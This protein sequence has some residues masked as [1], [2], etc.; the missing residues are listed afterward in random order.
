MTD[1]PASTDLPNVTYEEMQAWASSWVESAL[2]SDVTPANSSVTLKSEATTFKTYSSRAFQPP[3]PQFNSR[4]SFT[5]QPARPI[6][7][8]M[9]T[10]TSIISLTDISK[11]IHTLSQNQGTIRDAIMKEVFPRMNIFIQKIAALEE[12]I[13]VLKRNQSFST[14][15][16]KRLK[17]SPDDSVG[18]VSYKLPDPAVP[19]APQNPGVPVTSKNP[20]AP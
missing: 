12:E 2:P 6:S 17:P 5:E 7:N 18:K 8:E 9:P 16:A 20:E 11:S 3:Q 14:P 4:N 1:V 10:K 15:D 19:V 13:A